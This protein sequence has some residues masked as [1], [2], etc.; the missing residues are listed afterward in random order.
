MNAENDKNNGVQR[1]TISLPQDT[2]EKLEDL[3]ISGGWKNRSQ[4]VA[5]LIR[6]DYI[7]SCEKKQDAVMAGTIT[8]FYS[9]DQPGILNSI[10]EIERKNIEEVISSHKVLLE[11]NHMMEVLVVQGKVQKLHAIV[12]ELLNLKGVEAGKLALTSTILPPIQSPA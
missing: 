7:D 4:V 9:E 10:T 5:Q 12:D 2:F 8:L 6:Q 3:V 1:I 11:N